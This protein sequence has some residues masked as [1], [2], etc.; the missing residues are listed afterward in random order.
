MGE[1]AVSEGKE[2]KRK[3]RTGVRLEFMSGRRARRAR[4]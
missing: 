4:V 3:K 1:G 2:K